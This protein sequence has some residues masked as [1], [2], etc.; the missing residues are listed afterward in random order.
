MLIA[1]EKRK[2]NIAEY[3]LYIWQL[4]DLMRAFNFNL[5]AIK[6]NLVTKYIVDNKTQIEVY[7]YYENLI[8]MMQK[9]K[10][11][12]S[13]HIQAIKNVSNELNNFHVATI[14][15]GKNYQ[16]ISLYRLAKPLLDEFRMKSNSIDSHDIDVALNSLYGLML[17]N[18]QKKEVS[19]A[20]RLANK[21]ISKM[22]S[23]LSS[24]FK[25]YESG[26]LD[27]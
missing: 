16:Y 9:E 25:Q 10:I 1:Q 19:E 21:H 24:Q 8:M 6:I 27:L 15:S 12:S 3:I 11:L 13:G 5:D 23:S 7:K 17:L 26:K 18:I 4:E 22:L 20:T 2:T 14:K